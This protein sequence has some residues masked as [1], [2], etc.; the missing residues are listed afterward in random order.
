MV[1]KRPDPA[2]Q[3]V[4]A[5]RPFAEFG[6]YVERCPVKNSQGTG[7]LGASKEIYALDNY[8]GDGGGVALLW[9]D[10][11]KALEEYRRWRDDL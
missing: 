8:E 9:A 5:L 3:L 2:T 1:R 7:P 6:A 10:C 4:E 11:A